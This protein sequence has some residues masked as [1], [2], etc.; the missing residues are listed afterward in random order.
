MEVKL[1]FRLKRREPKKVLIDCPFKGQS[2]SQ[3]FNKQY[4]K[5]SV[6][7]SSDDTKIVFILQFNVYFRGTKCVLT[8]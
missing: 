8:V 3:C 7:P 1:K 2:T 6:L 5:L 4:I